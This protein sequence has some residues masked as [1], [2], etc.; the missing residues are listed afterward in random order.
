METANMNMF[1]I[2]WDDNAVAVF[3]AMMMCAQ[4][5][6]AD[7]PS[8]DRHMLFEPGRPPSW[9]IDGD[10]RIEHGNLVLGGS[11]PIRFQAAK[12]V[13][14]RFVLRI[15]YRASIGGP[16]QRAEK[17]VYYPDPQSGAVMLSTSGS[18]MAP[19]VTIE[20]KNLLSSAASGM[21][22]NEAVKDADQWDR[23]IFRGHRNPNTNNLEIAGWIGSSTSS[24]SDIMKTRPSFQSMADARRFG[25]ICINIP[26]GSQLII[27]N[28]ILD[29]DISSDAFDHAVLWV[30]ILVMSFLLVA[31]GG[32]IW[33]LRRRSRS[34]TEIERNG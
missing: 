30:L 22:L 16:P 3:L 29:G 7:P 34:A 11:N 33:R 27:R 21:G 17:G 10:C 25:A 8:P 24:E 1:R 20:F 32:F 18:R 4:P 19:G 12:L 28:A 15:D 5:V 2:L 6:S 13:G 26:N 31:G 14:D 9:K 23:V